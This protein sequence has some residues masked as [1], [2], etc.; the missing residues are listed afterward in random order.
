MAAYFPSS[1]VQDTLK[2]LVPSVL[3][4]ISLLSVDPYT[5]SYDNVKFTE[6]YIGV[7]KLLNVMCDIR[8]EDKENDGVFEKKD[9]WLAS[10]PIPCSKGIF[11]LEGRSYYTTMRQKLVP[12]YPV[13]SRSLV[14]G[15]LTMECAM[16]SEN[17][18]TLE[19]VSVVLRRS[20][21]GVRNLVLI[22]NLRGVKPVGVM[23][24]LRFYLG[25]LSSW[26]S[27]V[28]SICV[29]FGASPTIL[30]LVD[31]SYDT[32]T[33]VTLSRCYFPSTSNPVTGEQYL[34]NVNGSE[35]STQ[36]LVL[37]HMMV[38]YL[39][40]ECG[41]TVQDDRD[42]Y[43]N[44]IVDSYV[45]LMCRLFRKKIR[46]LGISIATNKVPNSPRICMPFIDAVTKNAWEIMEAKD[47]D[48]KISRLVTISNSMGQAEAARELM[49]YASS[50]PSITGD[51]ED[52][53]HRLLHPSQEG[54]V[55]KVR[56]SDDTNAGLK[57]YLAS[58][59]RVSSSCKVFGLVGDN[60]TALRTLYYKRLDPEDMSTHW[61]ISRGN[62]VI[63]FH[64]HRCVAIAH[65]DIALSV[66]ADLKH[67]DSSLCWSMCKGVLESR[68]Y[69]GRL[70]KA[71]HVEPYGAT[72]MDTRSGPV[73]QRPELYSPLSYE[74][75][76][77][78]MMPVPR[79][80]VSLKII[81]KSISYEIPQ[82]EHDASVHLAYGQTPLVTTTKPS[83]VVYGINAYVC[84]TTLA[85]MGVED[86][87]VLNR[88]SVERG[89]F[90][91][92]QRTLIDWVREIGVTVK[93]YSINVDRYSQV[94]YGT[95]LAVVT[96]TR[97]DGKEITHCIKH[98]KPYVCYAEDIHLSFCNKS[99]NDKDLM[100]LKFILARCKRIHTGDKLSSRFGQKGVVVKVLSAEDMPQVMDHRYPPTPDIVVNPLSVLS[101]STMSQDVCSALGVEVLRRSGLVA[102]DDPFE[103]VYINLG[104]HVE[105]VDMDA[106]PQHSVR[107]MSGTTGLMSMSPA[108]VGFEYYMVLDHM[109]DMKIRS[110]GHVIRDDMTGGIQSNKH[111]TCVRYNW[112]ELA[113]MLHSRSYGLVSSIYNAPGARG[114][115]PFCRRCNRDIDTHECEYCGDVVDDKV[116][117]SKAFMSTKRLMQVIGVEPKIES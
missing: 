40:L 72:A 104:T 6:G 65:M 25:G 70:M 60:N 17:M 9:Y 45:T 87:I 16:R 53:A 22:P 32:A 102:R 93:S 18:E 44:K 115:Y 3:R 39:S 43:S 69:Y 10:I 31:L 38:R 15:R 76:F 5:I 81:Q 91:T 108:K 64:N 54:F 57:L 47:T 28:H 52:Y 79:L 20:P 29:L 103:A 88:Q 33:D 36:S 71:V 117:V 24:L 26:R 113:A 75:P 8:I 68:C 11:R 89:L 58:G 101:R 80:M 42:D 13:C 95:V 55:C 35:V 106:L 86:G 100:S 77:M 78:N 27:I 62:R 107:V 41:D 51:P 92:L 34:V 30:S 109:S 114:L 12:N 50:R 111:D 63:W 99:A 56:T 1:T 85:G 98:S 66:L 4:G 48:L 37:C 90:S 21:R 46:L 7:S 67:R 84:Y 82:S 97:R 105:T 96:C 73:V 116:Q 83:P 23:S 110:D 61:D 94:K 49:I 112:Q 74:V 59:C 19:S 2:E 14:K